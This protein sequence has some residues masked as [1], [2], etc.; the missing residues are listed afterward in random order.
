[1]VSNYFN[2]TSVGITGYIGEFQLNLYDYPAITNPKQTIVYAR[3]NKDSDFIALPTSYDSASNELRFTSTTIGDFAFGVPQTIDSSYTPVPMLPKDSTIVNGG[4]SVKFLWGTRGIV[5]TY[6]LQVSNDP[7]FSNLVVDNSSLT[8]TSFTIDSVHNDTTY[9]WRINNTNAAGTSN[10]SNTEIFTTSAPFIKI[11]S[12]NGG[13]KFYVDSSYVI[14][15]QSNINDTVN[16]DLMNGNTVVAKIGDTI[17]SGTNAIKWS[18]PLN[19]PPDSTYKIMVTSISNAGISGSSNST[20]TILSG[21]TGVRDPKNIVRSYALYQNYPDPF[22]PTATIQYDLPTT[23]RVSLKI[24][25]LLGQLV[26]TVYQGVEEPGSKSVVWSAVNL[27]S[28]VYFYKLDATS[29]SDP[30]KTFSQI[31]KMVLLK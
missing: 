22:N 13:E 23:S 7:T 2:F 30:A 18:I 19:V 27:S 26:A 1:M 15:W 17:Y 20:L 3:S 16:I 24:Y 29:T 5:Q 28:G 14:R 11:L 10:W 25:N 9:Y 21:V 6:H 12:P 4:A 31:R 8:T